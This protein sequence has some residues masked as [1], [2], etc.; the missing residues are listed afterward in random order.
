MQEAFETVQIKY[1]PCAVTVNHLHL[2]LIN[3]YL[4]GQKQLV[5][6]V[7]M[8]IFGATIWVIGVISILTK[9]P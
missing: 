3:Y 5:S 7:K 6:R 4:E 8:A 1:W 2:I 9:S